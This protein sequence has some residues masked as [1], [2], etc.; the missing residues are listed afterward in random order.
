MN[1]LLIQLMTT[2]AP[3]HARPVTRTGL[4]QFEARGGWSQAVRDFRFLR[5]IAVVSKGEGIEVGRLSTGEV[6]VLRPFSSE[7]SPTIEVQVN[8]IS[9]VKIRYRP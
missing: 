6:I 8:R 5:P 2:Y 1:P 7:G 3:H 9:T 4:R